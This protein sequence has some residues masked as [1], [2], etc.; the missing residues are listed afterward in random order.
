M[1]FVWKVEDLKLRTE[2]ENKKNYW[3]WDGIFDAERT[4]SREDKIAVVNE[5]TKGGFARFLEAVN[6]FE[7]DRDNLKK[8]YYGNIKTVSLIGWIKRNGYADIFDTKYTYGETYILGIRRKITNINHL[9]YYYGDMYTDIV[10]EAF[11]R[12]LGLYLVEETNYFKTHDDYTIKVKTVLNHPFTGAVIDYGWSSTEIFITDNDGNRRN[13]TVADMD[14][15]LAAAD[16][17]R[18]YANNIKKEFVF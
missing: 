11:H 13:L 16:K 14:K 12:V 7:K 17:I 6:K 10:D 15:L 9:A 2:V 8:D 18:D 4:L 1:A 5:Y 3:N